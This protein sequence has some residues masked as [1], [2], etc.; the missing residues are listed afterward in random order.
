M[1]ASASVASQNGRHG[2]PR[3]AGLPIDVII[4]AAV[5][6]RRNKRN[7]AKI[8]SGSQG[9]ESFSTRNWPISGIKTRR[10]RLV[11][12]QTQ[13]YHAT[14]RRFLDCLAIRGKA[15]IRGFPRLIADFRT[16][17]W[18]RAPASGISCSTDPQAP[19]LTACSLRPIHSLEQLSDPQFQRKSLSFRHPVASFSVYFMVAIV[20]RVL[21]HIAFRPRTPPS[22][23]D[24]FSPLEAYQS[25]ASPATTLNGSVISFAD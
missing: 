1:S 5:Y 9:L 11:V 4:P 13:P 20:L 18:R 16:G 12:Q 8:R 19:A 23:L 10:G 21:I 15:E 14:L 22:S 7:L 17:C 24:F 3:G 2:G 6:L 25:L